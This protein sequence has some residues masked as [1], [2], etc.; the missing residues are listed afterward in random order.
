MVETVIVMFNVEPGRTRQ[1]TRFHENRHNPLKILKLF[2]ISNVAI[3]N[4]DASTDTR[5]RM[6][7]AMYNHI[8]VPTVARR[9]RQR[10]RPDI[11]RRALGSASCA[12]RKPR[13]RRHDRLIRGNCRRP[14]DEIEPAS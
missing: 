2:P 7:S 3:E 12:R 6:V 1:L 10:L 4:R 11:L 13:S 9:D 8:V 14:H 5:T